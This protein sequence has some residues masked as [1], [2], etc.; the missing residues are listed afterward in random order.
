MDEKKVSLVMPCYNAEKYLDA[1]LSSILNQTY[2]NVELVVV[3]DAS[4]DNSP[5]VLQKWQPKFQERGYDM[6][7]LHHAENGGL[8]AAINTGLLKITGEYICFPDADDYMHPEFVSTLATALEKNLDFEWAMCD[9]E[10]TSEGSDDIRIRRVPRNSVYKNDFYDFLSTK[11]PH[12]VWLLMVR[13]EY[14]ARCVGSQIYNSRITQGW[15]ILY[16]LSY[17]GNYLRV[18]KALYRYIIHPISMESW[19][20]GSCESIIERINA[21]CALAKEVVFRLPINSEMKS[22]ANNALDL[23]FN[24]RVYEA[25]FLS[26]F[27]RESENI[28]NTMLKHINKTIENIP[29]GISL[30]LLVEYSL[31]MVLGADT[32]PLVEAY[33]RLRDQFSGGYIIYGAG[34]RCVELIDGLIA[35]FGIPSAILDANPN[36]RVIGDISVMPSLSDTSKDL[37]VFISIA[38]PEIAQEAELSLTR[39][40][41]S[42]FINNKEVINALRG[43]ESEK[44]IRS[45][46]KQKLVSL[47]V[48]C[49]NASEYLPYFFR[50]ILGQSYDAIEIIV[51]D[52]ASTDDTGGVLKR[53]VAVFEKRG[54]S[55]HV[56]TRKSNGG[57][58]AAINEGLSRFSGEYVCFPDADDWLYPEYV[59]SLS[60]ALENNRAY[61]WARCDAEQVHEENPRE[62]WR[63]IKNPKDEL[64]IGSFKRMISYKTPVYAWLMMARREY[65]LDCIPEKHINEPRATQE[66]A[67][68]FPLAYH[69]DYLLVSK[70]LYRY[71]YHKSSSSNIETQTGLSRALGYLKD[72]ERAYRMELKKLPATPE[73]QSL[74]E[75]IGNMVFSKLQYELLC[76]YGCWN[77]ENAKTVCENMVKELKVLTNKTEWNINEVYSQVIPLTDLCIDKLI[78]YPRLD[79]KST[80]DAFVKSLKK[81][82]G[83]SL[84]G[85]SDAA[86]YILPS[87]IHSFG[88]PKAIFDRN[89]NEKEPLYGISVT[90][91]HI[92][93][94]RND[95]VVVTIKDAHQA[96]NATNSL[97]KMGL[98]EVYSWND[99]ITIL[100]QK[101]EV[102]FYDVI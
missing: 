98:S 63:A 61:G 57:L 82:G 35:A 24:F 97:K 75:R 58:C 45:E 83:Y 30:R 23:T 37:P 6:V 1:M 92:D 64:R 76:K 8:C 94:I 20:Y 59:Q 102:Y 17:Y 80:Y 3:N 32:K 26:G 48:P 9:A 14:F 43:F 86:T 81:R 54:F 72:V 65:I 28:K 67:L 88:R 44:R 39:I 10:I 68:G 31:D 41:F 89:A 16:P 79:E 40:G 18:P 74:F 47:I 21:F 77:H 46:K 42:S 100:G 38:K 53:W 78:D 29:A 52:D 15:S 96:G 95:V 13:R 49:Y 73:E 90:E 84:Y 22:I 27:K 7:I 25:Y 50:S 36:G 34:N 60:D 85:A 4:T 87:F 19:Q 91:P 71:I 33:N 70:V 56:V 66:F 51:V 12:T 5:S 11:T 55:Y 93:T 62:I 99:A 69:G 101:Y 2:Q